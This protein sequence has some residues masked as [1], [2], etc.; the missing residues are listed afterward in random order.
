MERWMGSSSS[1]CLGPLRTTGLTREKSVF[2][3][4]RWRKINTIFSERLLLQRLQRRGGKPHSCTL[5]HPGLEI[6]IRHYLWTF[7]VRSLQTYWCNY[8]YSY[9]YS[10]FQSTLFWGDGPWYSLQS[11]YQDKERKISGQ[12]SST[13]KLNLLEHQCIVFSCPGCWTQEGWWW[14]KS[15]VFKG[16]ITI[17]NNI[18]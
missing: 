8:Y 15:R 14:T 9:L 10:Y 12:A 2:A 11:W 5:V 1:P 18:T 3:R 7:C 4:N 17:F 16:N 13:G 6:C